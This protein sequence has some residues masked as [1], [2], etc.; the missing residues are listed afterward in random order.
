MNIDEL[1]EIVIEI[2]NLC[3]N[4]DRLDENTIYEVYELQKTLINVVNENIDSCGTDIRVLL[5]KQQELILSKIVEFH[6]VYSNELIQNVYTPAVQGYRAWSNV[7]LLKDKGLVGYHLSKLLEAKPLMMF[8][9]KS[10]DYTFNE[11][12]PEQELIYFEDGLPNN[13]QY[14]QYLLNNYEKMDLL[15]IH[16]MYNHTIGFVDLYRQLRPDGKVFCGLDMNL[17]WLERISWDDVT[18]K[19]FASQCDIIA[20]SSSKIRDILNSMTEVSFPCYY[21]PN[22]FS[23]DYKLNV[24]ANPKRKKNVIL[25][26]GRIGTKQK[27]TN[28]LLI[29]FAEVAARMPDWSLRLVGSIEPE[30]HAQIK[31]FFKLYPF[32][33]ERVIFT[34]PIYD[35]QKLY[36]EYAEAKCFALTS[37][38]EGGTPNVYTEALAHGCKFI[39]SNV[40]AG[41][42]MTNF[43][44]LGEVYDYKDIDALAKCMLRLKNTSS[45]KDFEVHIP[46]ALKYANEVFDWKKNTKKLAYM[47]NN[48]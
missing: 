19:N 42:E 34:G 47:L 8:C 48:L 6:D 11:L 26:V 18:V 12:V 2:S 16:G 38:F 43:G 13:E 28:Y 21:L 36:N 22:G 5:C 40:D 23:N 17:E 29:A 9:S 30:Y 4:I 7:E 46:K 32:L 39:V 33:K 10:E 15:V 37:T 44:E 14:E 20:T 25:T 24:E 1:N 45:E 31:K 3:K 41:E 35:K 27:N